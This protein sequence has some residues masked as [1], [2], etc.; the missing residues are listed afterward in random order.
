M[1][2]YQNVL[3]DYLQLTEE[4][5]NQAKKLYS[6]MKDNEN[7]QVE[8]LQSLF[9]KRQQLID[10]LES[11]IQQADFQWTDEDKQII[12]QVKDF[13]Q[14]IESLMTGLHQSFKTQM[15]QINQTKQGSRKFIGAYQNVST[16][17][18]FIDKRK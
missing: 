7:G 13:Q 3:A 10:E 5:H 11:Y 17:G 8:N 16:E 6:N 15:K 9:E 4:I 1:S 18:S 2:G 12:H 14:M